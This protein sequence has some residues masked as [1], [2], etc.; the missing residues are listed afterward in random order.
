MYLISYA[1]GSYRQ[2][3]IHTA[4]ELTCVANTAQHL[5]Y[6]LYVCVCVCVYVQASNYESDIILDICAENDHL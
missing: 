4:I 6:S 1:T 3:S 2:L 5:Q